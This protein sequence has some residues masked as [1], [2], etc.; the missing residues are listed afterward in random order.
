MLQTGYCVVVGCGVSCD[1]VHGAIRWC[2]DSI[3]AVLDVLEPSQ[4][5]PLPSVPPSSSCLPLLTAL[6]GAAPPAVGPTSC[7]D[8]F[9]IIPLLKVVAHWSDKLCGP[10]MNLS[11][12]DATSRHA[13][14]AYAS[15]LNKHPEGR[16][17]G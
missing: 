3:R 5:G 17:V 6:L 15:I 1:H 11:L 7:V 9:I 16:C 8:V 13:L 4:Q 14:M 10:I 2:N 12:L